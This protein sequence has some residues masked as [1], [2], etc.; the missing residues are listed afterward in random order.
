M[1]KLKWEK[2]PG[3]HI[4]HRKMI[5]AGQKNW[6]SRVRILILLVEHFAIS[7]KTKLMKK[8]LILSSLLLLTLAITNCRDSSSHSD[9]PAALEEER[10]HAEP[11]GE[12]EPHDE[13]EPIGEVEPKGE[14]EPAD[15][16]EGH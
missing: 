16:V 10:L 12:V 14:V 1:F 8:L 7:L 2:L 4:F 11:V 5:P 15:E 6:Y 13:V 3:F 9:D